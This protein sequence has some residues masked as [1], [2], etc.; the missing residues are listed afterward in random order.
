MPTEDKLG[1]CEQHED[2]GEA[3]SNQ[4]GESTGAKARSKLGKQNFFQVAKMRQS[5]TKTRP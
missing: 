5:K 3:R 2:L 4:V 1:K